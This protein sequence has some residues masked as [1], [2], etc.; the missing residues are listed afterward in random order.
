MITTKPVAKRQKRTF[1][2]ITDLF[3]CMSLQFPPIGT[4]AFSGCFSLACNK[5]HPETRICRKTDLCCKIIPLT[6]DNKTFILQEI[7]AF[8]TLFHPNLIHCFEVR[9]SRHYVF[10]IMEEGKFGNLDGYFRKNQSLFD[11]L[12]IRHVVRQI[13]EAVSYSQTNYQVLF[14]D[15]KCENVFVMRDGKT[16]KLGD[17]GFA[18]K[19][20]PS[21]L[22]NENGPVKRMRTMGT[23]AFMSIESFN[24]VFDFTSDVWSIGV[25]LFYLLFHRLPFQG[26][27]TDEI[28]RSVRLLNWKLHV[29]KESLT[30]PTYVSALNLLKHIFVPNR[31]DRISADESLQHM[32]FQIKN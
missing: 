30:D 25:M 11:T 3:R 6:N 8:Q 17:F 16:V 13:M 12:L 28:V 7:K 22:P 21:L 1:L 29:P 2:P 31:L 14:Q 32:Y 27:D 15:I 19:L 23:P 10:L 5:E 20:T 24:E 4:G 18:L 9:V 26:K